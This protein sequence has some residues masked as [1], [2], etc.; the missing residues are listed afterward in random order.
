MNPPIACDVQLRV[1]PVLEVDVRHP[2]ASV[3]VVALVWTDGLQEGERLVNV[4]SAERE[5]R[6]SDT[7][8]KNHPFSALPSS[9]LFRVPRTSSQPRRRYL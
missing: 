5:L 7:D 8:L 3:Q 4:A 1:F 6:A 2:L 9:K